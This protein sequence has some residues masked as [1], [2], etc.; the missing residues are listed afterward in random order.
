M[1]PWPAPSGPAR[2]RPGRVHGIN[3]HSQ[4][5]DPPSSWRHNSARAGLAIEISPEFRSA[6]SRHRIAGLPRGARGLPS[7]KADGAGMGGPPCSGW[8]S[9]CR[10]PIQRTAGGRPPRWPGSLHHIGFAA[11]VRTCH[12]PQYVGWR[13]LFRCA[14][15]AEYSSSAKTRQDSY[16]AHKARGVFITPRGPGFSLTYPA[17]ASATGAWIRAPVGPW[18]EQDAIGFAMEDVVRCG[19]PRPGCGMADRAT[20]VSGRWAG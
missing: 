5:C 11:G 2:P 1:T 13:S 17:H 19:G 6:H 7:A 10:N 8:R 20:G 12:P 14:L 18:E 3:T 4:R 9:T 16:C 15:L